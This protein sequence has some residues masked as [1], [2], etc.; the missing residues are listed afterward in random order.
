MKYNQYGI[1][2]VLLSC[3]LF[4]ISI[5]SCSDN[6][7]ESSPCLPNGIPIPGS[8]D[9]LC[10]IY[11][12]GEF[13]E[14]EIREK[15]IGRWIGYGHS[16]SHKDSLPDGFIVDLT[17]LNDISKVR[18]ESQGVFNKDI[19]ISNVVDLG[20]L[21]YEEYETV[22]SKVVKAFA[23][24]IIYDQTLDELSVT[25]SDNEDLDDMVDS[26]TFRLRKE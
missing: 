2:T 18:I 7:V 13:C 1:A 19:I 16:C 12:E 15:F 23:F 9:C 14:I 6:A 26:C 24:D 22:G 5:L 20:F 11:Y 21:N 17:K 10:S 3:I 25:I 4:S 8:D